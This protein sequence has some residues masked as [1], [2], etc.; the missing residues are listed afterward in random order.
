M[1]QTVLVYLSILI[2][3]CLT[4]CIFSLPNAGLPEK[5]KK[6]LHFQ[7]NSDYFKPLLIPVGRPDRQIP[8]SILTIVNTFDNHLSFAQGWGDVWNCGT[9]G[10][11]CAAAWAAI[12]VDAQWIG[13]MCRSCSLTIIY[14]LLFLFLLSLKDVTRGCGGID[15]RWKPLASELVWIME[16]N[17][18]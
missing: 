4:F 9:S 16:S 1:E 14:Y 6:N 18:Q 11:Q 15:T 13:S 8:K 2:I 17:E 7:F 10:V 5:E 3:S 12:L